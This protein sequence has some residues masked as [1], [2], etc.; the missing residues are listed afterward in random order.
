MF[1]MCDMGLRINIIYS[2]GY[3]IAC[4]YDFYKAWNIFKRFFMV[5]LKLG[6]F[7]EH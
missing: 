4:V 1:L 5:I 2:V 3:Q 6:I 7:I